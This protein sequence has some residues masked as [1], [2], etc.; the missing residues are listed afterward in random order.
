MTTRILVDKLKAGMILAEPL[1]NKD[2]SKKEGLSIGTRLS[3]AH[4]AAIKTWGISSVAVDEGIDGPEIKHEAFQ[5]VK[6]RMH[7][8][9][10]NP[11]EE[12]IYKVALQRAEDLLSRKEEE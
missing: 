7:W 3:D 1:M 4:L 12:E 2:K 9:P 6:G 10:S 11:I 8:V 5:R